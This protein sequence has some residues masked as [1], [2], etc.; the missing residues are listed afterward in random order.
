MIGLFLVLMVPF[1]VVVIILIKYGPGGGVRR[2][3]G[4][5]GGDMVAKLEYRKKEVPAGAQDLGCVAKWVRPTCAK[6]GMQE[7][8][9]QY[10]INYQENDYIRVFPNYF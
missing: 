6:C 4:Y 3:C 10:F 9:A 5:C 2:Q 7:K 1:I 8:A